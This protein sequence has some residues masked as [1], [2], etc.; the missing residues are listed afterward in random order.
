MFDDPTMTL[1]FVADM[2][3]M[4]DLNNKERAENLKDIRINLLSIYNLNV[5]A[6]DDVDFLDTLQYEI[7]DIINVIVNTPIQLKHNHRFHR[8][9]NLVMTELTDP[10]RRPRL[11]QMYIRDWVME[12]LKRIDKHFRAIGLVEYNLGTQVQMGGH[13]VSQM[14][15]NLEESLSQYNQQD[16]LEDINFED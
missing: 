1:K 10:I 3:K 8:F 12:C 15:D 16:D 14:R 11:I 7:R 9:T 5:S 2:Y 13:V 6:Y 4:V